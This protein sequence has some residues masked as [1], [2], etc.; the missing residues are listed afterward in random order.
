[1]IR[2]QP[3]HRVLYPIQHVVQRRRNVVDVFRIDGRDES[4]VQPGEDLVDNFVAPVFQGE[5]LRGAAGQTRIPRANSV[6]EQPGCLRD[7]LHLLHKEV[8]EVLLAWQ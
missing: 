3:V 8:V 2:Y 5:D 4:L 6:E 7:D 1:M